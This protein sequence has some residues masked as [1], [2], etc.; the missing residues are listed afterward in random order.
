MCERPQGRYETDRNGLLAN[1][2]AVY[3]GDSAS[4]PRLPA[5]NLTF[6]VMANALRIGRTVRAELVK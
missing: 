5:K 2:R 1:T 6:T 4:V 3:I